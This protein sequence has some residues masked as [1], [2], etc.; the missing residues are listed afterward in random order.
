MKRKNTK[1]SPDGFKCW[2]YRI[3]T[4]E[5]CIFSKAGGRVSRTVRHEELFM[6]DDDVDAVRLS[7]RRALYLY[8]NPTLPWKILFIADIEVGRYEID[9]PVGSI[10]TSG[11]RGT[12][13][14]WRHDKLI[15]LA[16]ALQKWIE[17]WTGGKK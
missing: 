3:E 10:F 15:S 17:I 16:D 13:F 6:A 2:R 8:S 7:I 5:T 12:V 4:F 1:Q 9:R 11:S 14:D